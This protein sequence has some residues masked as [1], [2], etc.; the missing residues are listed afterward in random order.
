MDVK[1]LITLGPGAK[2]I[3]PLVFV[4]ELSVNRPFQ[5]SL[6]PVSMAGAY[7]SEAPGSTVS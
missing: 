4:I 5:P 6:M 1:S 3:R 2:I 7:P